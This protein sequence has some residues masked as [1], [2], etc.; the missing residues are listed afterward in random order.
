MLAFALH[1][2]PALAGGATIF[3]VFVIVMLFALAYG[4]YTRKGSGIDQHPQ[5]GERDDASSGAD[6]P[7]R[8][9]SA[10]DETEG[11]PSSFG[12]R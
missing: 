2:P 3:L 11:A 4:Y 10:E 7:S 5:G 9:S 1:A 6:G 8:I 12:T